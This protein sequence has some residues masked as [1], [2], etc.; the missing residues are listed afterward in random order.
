M[1]TQ[2]VKSLTLLV[3]AI[4]FLALPVAARADVFTFNAPATAPDAGDGGPNQVDLD[5]HLAYSWRI[6]G[7]TLPA[8]DTI[9]SATLTI[10]SIRNWDTNPNTLFIHLLNNSSTFSSAGGAANSATVGW[11]NTTQGV[12]NNSITSF[13][14]VDPNQA[15]V[16]TIAD[17]F[18]GG[19][20]ASNPLLA[21]NGADGPNN[22]FFAALVNLPTTAQTFDLTL[23]AAQRAALA[24]Y[25]A[26]G[27]NFAWGFDSDCHFWNSGIS[28]TFTTQGVATPEPTTMVLLG[29]ASGKFWILSTTSPSKIKAS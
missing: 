14:D 6:G 24:S 26:S 19:L 9:V 27:G 11:H 20:Y 23:D 5:H 12:T 15:P 10:T 22:T 17:N 21:A 8:G 28:F 18:A 7:V 25:V 29:S 1:E 16:G 4:A 3:V 13:V 2:I